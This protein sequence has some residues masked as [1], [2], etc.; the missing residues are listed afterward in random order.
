MVVWIRILGYIL[1][2]GYL[3]TQVVEPSKTQ[4]RKTFLTTHMGQFGRDRHWS[5]LKVTRWSCA[6]PAL[7]TFTPRNFST[8]A[9]PSNRRIWWNP[10][11]IAI[12]LKM[13]SGR[14]QINLERYRVG[15]QRVHHLSA[16][17]ALQQTQTWSCMVSDSLCMFVRT[18]FLHKN[19]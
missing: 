10:C 12:E 4:P 14:N 1:K 6:S 13:A 11:S 3:L 19:N 5:T 7:R 18:R 15:L 9:N 17:H 16:L 2:R 8:G